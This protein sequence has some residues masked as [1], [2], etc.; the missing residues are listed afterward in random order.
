MIGSK[1]KDLVGKEFEVIAQHGETTW[2][3]YPSGHV[4][5]IDLADCFFVSESPQKRLFEAAR[6]LRDR[7]RVRIADDST[8]RP[9][10]RSALLEFDVLEAEIY[11]KEIL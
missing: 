10:E 1:F 8:A 2:A 6:A 11:R 3:K 5:R 7:L 9:G 4:C